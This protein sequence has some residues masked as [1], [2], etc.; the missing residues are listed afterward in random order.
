MTL[1]SPRPTPIA[2]GTRS[3]SAPHSPACP[4]ST[5]PSPLRV[6]RVLDVGCGGGWSSIALARAYP[7]ATVLGVDTDQPSVDLAVANAHDAGLGERVRFLCQDAASLPEGTTDVTFG[8]ECVHDMPR[9]VEVLSAVRRTLAL[10]GSLIVMDEAVADTS[11]PTAT[12]WS[13]SCTE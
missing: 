10:G 12:T 8:F 7:W 13:R 9:P 3:S 11:P 4:R 2:R 6:A 1:G 5:T